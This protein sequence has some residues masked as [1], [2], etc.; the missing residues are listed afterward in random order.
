MK[1]CEKEKA[2][3]FLTSL[4]LFLQV[5][6]K[7]NWKNEEYIHSCTT[8]I[9][10]WVRTSY[11]DAMISSKVDAELEVLNSCIAH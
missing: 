4:Q 11:G 10:T 2:D 9:R 6:K 8:S 1:F 7:I 3:C 5:L